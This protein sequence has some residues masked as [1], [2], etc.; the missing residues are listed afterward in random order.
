[1]TLSAYERRLIL[2]YLS[3]AFKRFHSGEAEA[4]NLLQWAQRHED[5]TENCT[6]IW[7]PKTAHFEVGRSGA[8]VLRLIAT[9]AKGRVADG[10]GATPSRCSA[11]ADRNRSWCS[12][13][14]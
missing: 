2:S 11:T 6:Y 12:L 8:E 4:R 14:R 1:M 3:N 10:H 7:Q 13:I 5:Q 9:V